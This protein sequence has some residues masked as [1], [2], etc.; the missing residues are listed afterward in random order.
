MGDVAPPSN[1]GAAGGSLA[2]LLAGAQPHIQTP[3][4]LGALQQGQQLQTARY[5]N[6][7]LGAQLTQ[8]QLLQ[9]ATNPNGTVDYRKFNALVAQTPGAAFGAQAADQGAL[10]YAHK[11]YALHMQ[12]MGNFMSG[13]NSA[14]L[15]A[16]KDPSNAPKI[17]RNYVVD[18]AANGIMSPNEAAR[19]LGEIPSDP[20][21]AIQ[22]AQTLST[23]LMN[24]Q[25]Q[26]HQIAGAPIQIDNGANVLIGRQPPNG[27]VTVQG[28]VPKALSPAQAASPVTIQTPS[29][30]TTEPLGTFAG[31]G[32][33]PV[34]H[35]AL[36]SGHA[37]PAAQPTPAPVAAPATPAAPPQPATGL[38]GISY[39]SWAAPTQG[40]V[41][42]IPAGLPQEQKL[43]ADL[44]TQDL[45]EVSANA[46]KSNL[47]HSIVAEG[48]NA[49]TGALANYFESLG[50]GGAQLGL[51]SGE[52]A[53][54]L[55]LIQKNV[56]QLVQAQA[57]HLGV[58]TDQKLGEVILGNPNAKMTPQAIRGAAAQLLGMQN[59]K[60]AELNMFQKWEGSAPP[61]YQ[62]GA[63]A[64]AHFNQQF[65]AKVPLAV[66][67]LENMPAPLRKQYV[68]SLS[69]TEQ[70]QLA[71]G[72]NYAVSNGLIQPYVHAQ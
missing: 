11:Q 56:S 9:Q 13:L 46:Q 1:G 61:G 65:Q 45:K 12:R 10:D 69:K 66:F 15:T 2:G 41:Y 26:A 39:P 53:T 33:T 16:Q 34:A 58:P 37:T 8:G 14:V 7:A 49:N 17:F 23:S 28:M 44:Y 32:G 21:Q 6:Q 38:G 5:H 18:A 50:S 19:V 60:A 59:Y 70:K 27:P 36:G 29:G 51:T 3:N 68:T 42:N 67:A 52:Q 30:Q 64:Y 4:I 24:A 55:N 47:L 22:A 57:G 48:A 25:A 71:D 43:S 62:V 20:Q 63:A 54:D 31:G 40:N 72:Y 35:N